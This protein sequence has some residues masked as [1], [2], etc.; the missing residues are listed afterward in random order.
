MGPTLPTRTHLH[1]LAQYY[2]PVY[3]MY[4]E[5]T[6][7]HLIDSFFTLFYI[8]APT[9]F[10][11]TASSSVSSDSLAAKLHEGVPAVLVAFHKKLSHSSFRIVKTLKLFKLQKLYCRHNSKEFYLRWPRIQ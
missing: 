3:D 9:C 11:A 2:S 7:A 8:I 1:S 4:N 10:N 5:Q 6:D